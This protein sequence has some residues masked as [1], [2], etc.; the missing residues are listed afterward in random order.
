MDAK[1][2]RQLKIKTN[3]LLRTM[4]DHSSYSNE[5]TQQE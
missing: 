1:L 3:V 2:A 4:K 5:K